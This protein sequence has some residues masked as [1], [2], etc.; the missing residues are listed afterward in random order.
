MWDN[1]LF[2]AFAD[3]GGDITT[4]ASNWPYRG[5]KGTVWEGGTRAAAFIHSPNRA[6]IPESR[7]GTES[8]ALMHVTDWLPTLLGLAGAS[9]A[10]IAAEGK[11]LDGVDMMAGLLMDGFNPTTNPRKEMLYAMDMVVPKGGTLAMAQKQPNTWYE[12]MAI[13]VGHWKLIEGLPGRGDWYGE[14]PSLAWPVD[15]IM[16]PDAT[17]Y[18][19]IL[20]SR[21]GKVGDGGQLQLQRGEIDSSG[22]KRRWLFDLSSDPT[23][24]HDLSELRPDKV[25][26]LLARLQ[27]LQAE[28]VLPSEGAGD[29]L[30]AFKAG[31]GRIPDA[32]IGST[33]SGRMAI[34]TEYWSQEGFPERSQVL[35]D[36]EAISLMD[37]PSMPLPQ[38]RPA[39][40]KL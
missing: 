4:A 9:A 3:N 6:I 35:L 22:L 11:P 18:A 26:E 10:A 23:E 40:S 37:P 39:R 14:D 21:G 32:K 19:A 24:H 34:L 15:Y 16:G 36:G 38:A 7:R 5:T 33:S 28:Q 25:K 30:S 31:G 20:H 1:T 13:R 12:V 8:H 27:E 29:V 2:I 17:D